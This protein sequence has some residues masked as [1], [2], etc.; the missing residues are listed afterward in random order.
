MVAIIFVLSTLTF[1]FFATALIEKKLKVKRRIEQFI[2][3]ERAETPDKKQQKTKQ[4]K[5]SSLKDFVK[6]LSKN[7]KT[8]DSKRDK[9]E[10][11][12]E[13]AGLPLKVEE[14]LVI[15]IFAFAL[16]FVL[17]LLLGIHFLFAIL[18]GLLCW[19]L[20]TVYIRMKKK[21]RV[22]ACG[23]Q[24]PQV[25]EIMANAMKSG[26]SFMQAMQLVSKEMPDPIGV[27]FQKTIKE[28][29]L[30]VPMEKAFENL[31]LRLPN[32][33]L[34][35]VLTAVLIQ[36][37]TG[38]NLAMILE[39]IQETITERVRMKEELKA[40]TAQGRMSASVISLLPVVLGVILNLINPEYFSPM[41]SHPLGWLLLGGG[42]FSGIL[43][44]VFIQKVVTIEV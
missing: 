24:L 19:K 2:P 31:L 33:D 29:N 10:A 9:L 43:G 13:S 14:F 4:A 23:S 18:V 11:E 20:P 22:N 34:E 7:I 38:G 42:L 8:S 16:G 15:R 1:G 44:W 6:V 36:R 27:E 12:I 17:P 28:I 32:Q 37:S 3:K 21:S 30:G 35:M 5:R 25:L 26:F 40:L 41:F 39:T